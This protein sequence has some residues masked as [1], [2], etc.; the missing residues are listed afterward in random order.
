MSWVF[1]LLSRRE[2][3]KLGTIIDSDEIN[4]WGTK[5]VLT[6]RSG[7]NCC[8]RHCQGIRVVN[9]T[10]VLTGNGSIERFLLF[11]DW[12]SVPT[13]INGLFLRFQMF[14]GLVLDREVFAEFWNSFISSFALYGVKMDILLFRMSYKFASRK[15]FITKEHECCGNIEKRIIRRDVLLLISNFRCV[16]NRGFRNADKPQSDAWEMP[17][18]TYT[19]YYYYY[20]CFFCMIR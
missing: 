4:K 5:C 15:K 16:L 1:L 10:P 11:A 9:W 17:K 14:Q 18:R 8:A 12:Y 3:C 7:V 6:R 2:M 20:Y 13:E 19:M